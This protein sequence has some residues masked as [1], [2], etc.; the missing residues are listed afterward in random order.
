M[1]NLDEFQLEQVSEW[2]NRHADELATMLDIETD[3]DS[4]LWAELEK[5]ILKTFITAKV[6]KIEDYLDD[7][8]LGVA[9]DRATD[10]LFSSIKD[11]IHDTNC[12][13]HLI[14]ELFNYLNNQVIIDYKR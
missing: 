3:N 8:C 11:Q 5:Q 10:G 2:L 4:P 14:D 9:M 6:E 7:I 1:E 12:P 13:P